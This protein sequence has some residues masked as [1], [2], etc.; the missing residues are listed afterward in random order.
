MCVLSR[1]PSAR[2]PLY[3][4]LQVKPVSQPTAR[5]CWGAA[6]DLAVA[7]YAGTPQNGAT[8]EKGMV[9]VQ[10]HVPKVK[11]RQPAADSLKS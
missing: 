4:V 11:V 2:A 5:G 3:S 10:E 6:T 7:L 9:L 8:K 1:L